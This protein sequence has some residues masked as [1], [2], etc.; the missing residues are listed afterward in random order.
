[1]HCGMRAHQ[2]SCHVRKQRSGWGMSARWRPSAEVRAAMP[3]G[4]PLGLKGYASVA[5]PNA[6]AY[7]HMRHMGSAG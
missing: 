7:L 2:G 5:L 4:E 3:S 6:S 1:M